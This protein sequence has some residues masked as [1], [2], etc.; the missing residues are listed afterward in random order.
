MK[1]MQHDF[2]RLIIKLPI[3]WIIDFAICF[4][5]CLFEHD[6]IAGPDVSFRMWADVQIIITI[7]AVVL[8]IHYL[9]YKKW[10]PF[11]KKAYKILYWIMSYFTLNQYLWLNTLYMF[12][13]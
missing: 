7:Y 13:D 4:C 12:F 5:V 9:L 2:I 6:I 11:D 8:V 3:L 10:L 1:I